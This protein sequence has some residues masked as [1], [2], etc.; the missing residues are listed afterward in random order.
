MSIAV[1]EQFL[2]R[3]RHTF[4]CENCADTEQF[5]FPSLTLAPEINYPVADRRPDS[6]TR[7]L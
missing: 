6:A 1:V 5:V 4:I 7:R 3:T 2:D